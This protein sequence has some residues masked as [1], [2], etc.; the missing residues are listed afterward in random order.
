MYN[1][2]DCEADE[3]DDYDDDCDDDD[4]CKDDP[5]QQSCVPSNILLEKS[6]LC[7]RHT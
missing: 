7:G 5:N 3:Y 1:D 6:R 2:D 4:D